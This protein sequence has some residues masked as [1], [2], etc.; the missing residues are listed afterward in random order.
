MKKLIVTL[1]ILA[2]VF[3]NT[4][5]AS[6]STVNVINN[7]TFDL[8]DSAHILFLSPQTV[9]YINVSKTLGYLEFNLNSSW[10]VFR[11]NTDKTLSV[12]SYDNSSD[13]YSF[14]GNG[15]SGNLNITAKMNSTSTTYGLYVD[16]S[17]ATTATSNSTGWVFLNYTWS[18]TS[19]SFQIKE[20]VAPVTSSGGGRWDR[21]LRFTE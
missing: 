15:A 2:A 8:S 1:S 17:S 20:Y 4:S 13:I 11:T 6:A 14:T 10:I 7:A 21:E 3:L 12:L 5:I 18:G 9:N 19:H 16:G